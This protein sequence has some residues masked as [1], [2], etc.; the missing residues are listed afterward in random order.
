MLPCQ[1]TTFD[2]FH[3]WEGQVMGSTAGRAYS[4]DAISFLVVGFELFGTTLGEE[5][6][7]WALQF[8]WPVLWCG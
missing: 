7:T 8:G 6:R 4:S 1:V 5:T 2:L 3:Y